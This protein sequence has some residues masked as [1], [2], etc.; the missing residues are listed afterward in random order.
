MPYFASN[1][2]S[3]GNKI[4]SPLASS[5][6]DIHPIG[7][8]AHREWGLVIRLMNIKIILVLTADMRYFLK[9]DV[10]FDGC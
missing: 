2:S 9:D 6:I 5:P 10:D 4:F 1:V 7:H 8:I 3:S